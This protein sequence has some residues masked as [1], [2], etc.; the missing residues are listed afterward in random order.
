MSLLSK[1]LA[2]KKWWCWHKI[3]WYLLIL[4]AIK[5]D[6]NRCIYTFTLSES[7]HNDKIYHWS[8]SMETMLVHTYLQCHHFC[9]WHFDLFDV[10]CKQNHKTALNPLLNSTW[11][12]SL[13]VTFVQYKCTYSETLLIVARMSSIGDVS[14][15]SMAAVNETAMNQTT[16]ATA[17]LNA[18]KHDANNVTSA[19]TAATSHPL[20][21]LDLTTIKTSEFFLDGCKVSCQQWW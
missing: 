1:C 6:H 10:T 7:E 11:K 13:T 16:N 5:I 18:T 9:E 3:I 19:A 14:A 21:D 8:I 2:A 20:D 4:K 12:L 15:I 17:Y